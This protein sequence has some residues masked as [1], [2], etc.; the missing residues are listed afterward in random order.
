MGPPRPSHRYCLFS[1]GGNPVTRARQVPAHS[2]PGTLRL[3]PPL[4]SPLTLPHP[5]P[6]HFQEP[7]GPQFT[8]R[9]GRCQLEKIPQWVRQ[10]SL[11]MEWGGG[12]FRGALR[13][14]LV[15][16][17]SPGS[18]SCH[19]PA[20]PDPI[21]PSGL[22]LPPLAQPRGGRAQVPAA[23]HSPGLPL[24]GNPRRP[25]GRS[26]G[27]ATG[28]T[29]SQR[30]GVHAAWHTGLGGLKGRL[31]AP[32]LSPSSLSCTAASCSHLGPPQHPHCPPHRVLPCLTPQ[33]WLCPMLSIPAVLHTYTHTLC[34]AL[35]CPGWQVKRRAY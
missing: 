20:D 31:Q 32:A 24:G 3:L 6:P 34:S 18:P 25:E 11:G 12:I 2:S 35:S 10:F 15:H 27:R 5:R 13:G 19:H 14:H 29:L 1:S 7:L 30:P 28:K 8:K 33:G 9:A 26:E 16:L 22:R 4:S 21:A 17:L 23:P